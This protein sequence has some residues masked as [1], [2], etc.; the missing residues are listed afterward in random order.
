M[1]ASKAASCRTSGGW[2]PKP[3]RERALRLLCV[4]ASLREIPLLL[5]FLL[6]SPSEPD[7]PIARLKAY[8]QERYPEQDFSRLLLVSV[9]RQSLYEIRDWQVLHRYDV[10]T[11]SKGVGNRHHSGQT[12]LGLHRVC[13]KYGKRV[14]LGGILRS[15][16]YTGETATIYTDNTDLDSNDVTTRVLS[17]CGMEPGV[18]KGRGIDSYL[19]NIYI[20]GT[21]EEGLLGSPASDGCIRMRNSEIIELFKVVPVDTLVLIVEW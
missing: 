4:L 3:N 14:P 1:A 6:A 20:H 8:T 11:S 13:E 10:S 7:D 12:P 19:R 18:N 16:R 9:A 2:L 17:L 21:P 15:R 5:T